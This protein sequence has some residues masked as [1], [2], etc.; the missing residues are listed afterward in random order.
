MILNSHL[1]LWYLW[2]VCARNIQRM[3]RFSL[4]YDCLSIKNVRIDIDQLSHSFIKR[5]DRRQWQ[6]MKIMK[7]IC[8]LPITK[9]ISARRRWNFYYVSGT[10]NRSPLSIIERNKSSLNANKMLWCWAL[11]LIN[12]HVLNCL[13]SSQTQIDCK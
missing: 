4:M 10:C 13:L 9:I 7:L 8:F 6:L 11:L 5:H 3:P 12:S 2:C 1:N